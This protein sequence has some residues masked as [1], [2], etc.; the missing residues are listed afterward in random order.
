MVTTTTTVTVTITT[1]DRRSSLA[2]ERVVS[3]RWRTGWVCDVTTGDFTL[4]TDEPESVPGGTNSGPQPTDLLLAAVSSCFAL[5]VAH[6]SRKRSV[7]L[8]H[9]D[10]DVTGV[11]HGLSFREIRIDASI[12]CAEEELERVVSAAER[13]CYVTNTIRGGAEIVISATAAPVSPR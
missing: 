13:S 5:S 6:V 3:G 12:G 11:Y 4:R 9:V 2:M 8:T 7:D 1:T 10:V